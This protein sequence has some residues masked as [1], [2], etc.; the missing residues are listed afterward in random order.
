MFF[1]R[2]IMFNLLK[3]SPPPLTCGFTFC[4]LLPTVSCSQKILGGKFQ[5]QFT[6]FKL[7]TVLSSVM[8]SRS[9]PFHP[10]RSMYHPFVQRV[11]SVSHLVAIS[12][13]RSI[14]FRFDYCIY[15][16]VSA[17]YP[18]MPQIFPAPARTTDFAVSIMKLPVTCK[19]FILICTK[20]RQESLELL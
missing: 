19:Y 1:Q 20:T 12:V 7:L 17:L 6:S 4:S 14:T 10:T 13:V 18:M 5:K 8:K 2:A 15:N 11:S 3:S 9:I 16:L